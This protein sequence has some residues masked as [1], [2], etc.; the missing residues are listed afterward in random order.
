MADER[1]ESAAA[2][3][4]RRRNEQKQEEER[5]AA[6][7]AAARLIEVVAEWRKIIGQSIIILG[8]NNAPVEVIVKR[9]SN[10]GYL[11]LHVLGVTPADNPGIW[12]ALGNVQMLDAL[13]DPTPLGLD[14]GAPKPPAPEAQK[15]APRK[16]LTEPAAIE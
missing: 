8:S 9:V 2:K 3:A 15:R 12:I 11:C 4:E 16:K 1:I 10:N 6:I 5:R 14:L 7:A 13:V